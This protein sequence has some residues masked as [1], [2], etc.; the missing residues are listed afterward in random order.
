MLAGGLPTNSVA[1][2]PAVTGDSVSTVSAGVGND[3]PIIAD[4]T[5]QVRMT[6]LVSMPPAGV[7]MPPTSTFVPPTVLSV[8]PPSFTTSE[9]ATTVWQ[10]PH[11]QPSVVAGVDLSQLPPLQRQ[12]FLRLHQQQ[13]ETTVHPASSASHNPVPPVTVQPPG[14]TDTRCCHFQHL[15]VG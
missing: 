14:I 12:L 7:H 8:A 10:P 11:P 2:A 5:S 4:T 13:K 9:A 3:S 1:V 15:F 6:G